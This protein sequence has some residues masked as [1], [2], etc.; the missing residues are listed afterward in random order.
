M[1]LDG[2]FLYVVLLVAVLTNI[3]AI[4]SNH[5]QL[6][7]LL[8]IKILCGLLAYTI[9]ASAWSTNPFRAIAT[10]GFLTLLVLLVCAIVAERKLLMAHARTIKRF[11][12]F[13]YYIV[14]A[15]CLWQIAGE[16]FGVPSSLTLL[17][18]MYN[19]D[20]FGIARPTG[21][22]LEPQFLASLLLPPLLWLIWRR[23]G[24]KYPSL[25]RGDTW[26]LVILSGLLILTLSRGGMLAFIVGL[27]CI[28]IFSSHGS[29]KRWAKTFGLLALGAALALS[30]IFGF[31]GANRSTNISGYQSISRVMN[32]LSFSMISLPTDKD[33]DLTLTPSA[34]TTNNNHSA[35]YVASSTDSRLGMSEQ[36]LKL[37]T[38]DPATTVFGVGTGGFGTALYEAHQADSL[39]SI[40]NNM[41][42]EQLVETGLIGLILLLAFCIS[43]LIVVYRSR[44][45]VLLA[46]LVA[47]FVQWSFFSGNANVIHMWVVIAIAI[48]VS[49]I[50]TKKATRSGTIS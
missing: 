43:L 12:F 45:F 35:G 28:A 19:A 18:T 14:A 46:I 41:Y 11:L 23:I 6:L 33:K 32:H 36:A 42:I 10:S 49:V 13:S 34:P 8:P 22:A 27:L 16:A 37:W 17:P 2:T 1:H 50:T 44:Q 4:W 29:I 31:A 26:M 21:F 39:G 30:I 48:S 38:R 20:V 9:L 40:V 25:P 7:S 24:V 3:P 5:R 15:W 47:C